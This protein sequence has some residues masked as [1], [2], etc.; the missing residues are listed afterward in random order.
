MKLIKSRIIKRVGV[1]KGEQD[2]AA[3][4]V[5]GSFQEATV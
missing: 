3:F 1:S 5:K 2:E 4:E